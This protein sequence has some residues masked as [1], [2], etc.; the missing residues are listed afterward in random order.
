M[1]TRTKILV[2]VA[3]LAVLVLVLARGEEP[4]EQAQALRGDPM[5][6]YTPPGG[7][8]IQ[9]ESQN[10][11]T[12]LGK[13]VFARY[14]RLFEVRSPARQL[15]QARTA[16][17]AAG[18]VLE[19]PGFELGGSTSFIAAKRLATGG[20]ELTVTLYTGA[21]LLP[22]GVRPPALGVSLRHRSA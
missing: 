1:S 9:T 14:S 19:D 2:A 13:P 10:E 12:S 8:L 21:R 6:S 7:T 11:G 15:E 17:T 5:A 16:A 18:W 20:A 22:R 3:A 4:S